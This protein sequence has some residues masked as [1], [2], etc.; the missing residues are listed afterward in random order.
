[1]ALLVSAWT[2]AI[3]MTASSGT[4]EGGRCV[5][6][7]RGALRPALL[8]PHCRRAAAARVAVVSTLLT[9]FAD[10]SGHPLADNLSATG[11]T[12]PVYVSR[13]YA[14]E[15]NRERVCVNNARIR[16]GRARPDEPTGLEI[17]AQRSKSAPRS[18]PLRARVRCEPRE[19]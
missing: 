8:R 19:A 17:L 14:V 2:F 11:L 12:L 18:R 16:T 13:L 7:S 6:F 1:M 10:E 5:C 15:G 3:V 4:V 9:D